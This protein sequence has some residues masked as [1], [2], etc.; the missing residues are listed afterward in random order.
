MKNVDDFRLCLVKG[1]CAWFTTQDLSR[2]CGDGWGVR[3][4]ITKEIQ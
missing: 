3:T 1:N 2:Q 4:G